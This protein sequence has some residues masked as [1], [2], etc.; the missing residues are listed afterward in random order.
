MAA[1]R[2]DPAAPRDSITQIISARPC[3]Q[4]IEDKTAS[5]TPERRDSP[6]QRVT[7]NLWIFRRFWSLIL[8]NGGPG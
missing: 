7:V 4:R 1:D 6:A 8:P 3:L 2:S 5:R